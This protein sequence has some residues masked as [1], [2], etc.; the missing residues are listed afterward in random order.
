MNEEHI[1]SQWKV[2]EPAPGGLLLGYKASDLLP[3]CKQQKEHRLYR[4]MRLPCPCINE[5]TFAYIP[6]IPLQIVSIPVK[7]CIRSIKTSPEK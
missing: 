5:A 2:Y 7:P 3:S 1:E 6:Y 4:A